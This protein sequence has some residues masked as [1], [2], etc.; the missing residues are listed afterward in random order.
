MMS[1]ILITGGAG[2]IGS[3]LAEFL[4]DKGL[5]VVILDNF[6]TGSRENIERIKDKIEVL[7]LDVRDIEGLRK[8][9]KDIDYIFHL[10][11]F[12][13]VPESVKKRCETFEINVKGTK[14]IL[15][16]AKEIGA[17]KVIIPSSAAVYGDD[18]ELPKTEDSKLMPLSPYAESKIQKERLVKEFSKDIETAALRLFNVYGPNQNPASPYAAVIPIFI[19]KALEGKDLIIYGDGEQTRDFIY[20]KDVC[21]AFLSAINTKLN[22]DI[23]NIASGKE[24]SINELAK[25]IIELTNSKSKVV[26]SRPREGDIIRSVAGIDLSKEKLNFEP[27]YSLDTGLK[28]IIN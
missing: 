25:K 20:I 2:F 21:E 15:E 16:I 3:N 28:E 7:E 8:N 13:S 17:K 10:A 22:G 12:V 27:K 14:N 5:D 6:S 11:A 1:K 23:I 26:Y 4:L 18:P 9:L 19:K 24:L